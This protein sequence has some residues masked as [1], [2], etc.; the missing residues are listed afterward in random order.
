MVKG[1]SIMKLGIC[2]AGGGVKG[3]AHIGVLKAFEEENI[4]FDYVSGTSSGS[5]VAT[6]Y[7]CG[8]SSKEIYELF[9]K[10]CKDIKYVDGI[11]IIKAIYGLIFKRKIIIDGLT[12][13]NKI[14]KIIN[15]SC[16]EKQIKNIN[17]IEKNLIIPAVDLYDGRLYVF[18]SKN[19]R[20][21]YSN[22]I[23]YIY[24]CE[25]GKVVQ[26]SCSYPGIFSPCE[27]KNTKLIDGGIRENIPWKLT[28]SNGAEKV[29]SVVFEKEI[30]TDRS[31]KKNIINVI[32]NSIDILSYELS[33][34]ELAGADYLLKIK[35]KNIE[36]LD[37]NKIN[38][39]YKLGYEIAKEKINE[40][41]NINNIIL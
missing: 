11:N 22:D 36:L 26:A 7:A 17:E 20:Q 8:Y 3:A 12:N 33:N 25:I 18:S 24:D 31:N 32:N 19:N 38:Y 37:I 15:I 1:D 35:T 9:K 6:L 30:N 5:I 14:R 27:Y 34:Y 2:F 10:Y 4:D 29:I 40:I 13:G 21:I 16:K 41:K 39:L 28:K 23:L